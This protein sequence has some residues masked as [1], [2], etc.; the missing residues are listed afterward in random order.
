MSPRLRVS[1][2]PAQLSQVFLNLISNAIKFSRRGGRIWIEAEA[3]G[4]LIRVAVRDAGPGIAPEDQA[5]IFE[6]FNNRD[7][8]AGGTGLGLSIC[9]QI[10]EAHGGRIWVESERNK[11]ASLI[12]T[13]ARA[14]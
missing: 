9:R 5:K 10:L 8:R 11:G 3:Q 1:A 12:F 2:D 7:A 13:L 4:D 14:K 6:R